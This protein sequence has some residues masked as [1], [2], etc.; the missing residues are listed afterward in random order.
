MHWHMPDDV[1]FATVLSIDANAGN[2]RGLLHAVL[3]TSDR[4]QAET[5]I[6]FVR[7]NPLALTQIPPYLL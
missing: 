1:A 3:R 2:D 4:E 6:L 7:H 5:E